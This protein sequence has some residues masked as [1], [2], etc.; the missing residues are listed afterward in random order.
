MR[1]QRSL[2]RKTNIKDK[3]RK[4]YIFTE[5]VN[6]EKSYIE[7]YERV[8]K[9]QV[10]KIITSKRHGTPRTLLNHAIQ[11][12]KAISSKAYKRDNGDADEIWIVFDRDEHPYV[13]ET[14]N[15]CRSSGINYAYSNPCFELWLILHFQDFDKHEHRHALQGLCEKVC[16]G[17]NKNSRKMP[18]LDSLFPNVL[19][20]E[21]RA[22]AMEKRRQRDGSEAPIT[23][24]YRLTRA[25]RAI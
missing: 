23:T 18:E 12:K 19:D 22:E 2:N 10:I 7:H 4:I 8:V 13:T 11:M 14:I 24:M 6:S 17:Y 5:G 9:S 3:R 25:M 15:A 1:P 16:P 20:A 21:Q